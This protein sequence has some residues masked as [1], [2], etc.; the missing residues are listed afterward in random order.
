MKNIFLCL[1]F[2]IGNKMLS[3]EENHQFDFW[4]G[5]WT[6]YKYGTDSL[7][8][9]SHIKPILNHQSIEENYSS[10]LYPYSGKSYNTYNGKTKQWEQFWVDN[11][12][13]RLFLKGSLVDEKMVLTNC[14]LDSI[15]NKIVWTPLPNKRVRQEWQHSTDKG[16]TWQKVFD[17]LYKPI[18]SNSENLQEVLSNLKNFPNVRDF[19]VS[20]SGNEAYFTAQSPDEEVSVIISVSKQ[21]GL[22]TTPKLV[23]F[24]G[25]YKDLEPSLS[26]DNKRLFFVS[27]RPLE[28][29]DE[30]PKDFDIWYVERNSV[31]DNWSSPINMGSPINTEADEFYPSLA[32]NGNLYF[33]SNRNSTN[34]KDDIFFSQLKDG[35]YTQPVSLPAT[36]NSKGYE[37]N[38]FV[39]PD[40]SYLIFSGY[41][42]KDGLGSGDLYISYNKNGAW[43]QAKN[44]GKEVNSNKMDYCPFVDMNSNT[45]YFTS[46]RSH[47]SVEKTTTIEELKNRI[48]Q[49]Q[50]GFSRIYAVPMN[51]ISN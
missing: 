28:A 25:K 10:T 19:T 38:A 35:K 12:G 50:N 41:N 29:S 8:G 23:S 48:N 9:I 36:I 34:G 18:R 27:N 3:Q 20:T 31:K 51:A 33:T 13:M 30:Q 37:F 6:V 21:N 24:S 2:L 40:E 42:R 32:A 26:L 16:K 46:K 17:G 1:V 45:L 5:D 22:W 43:N 11:S 4:I 47:I 14:E 49:Y 44:L 7:V 39:A 15:C